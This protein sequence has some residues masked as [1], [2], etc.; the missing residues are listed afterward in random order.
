MAEQ[1]IKTRGK[2]VYDP[3]RRGFKKGYKVRTLIAELPRDELDLYYQWFLKKRYGEWLWLQRPMFGLHVTVVRGDENGFKSNLWGAYAGLKVDLE[4][5][6]IIRH[7]WGFWSLPVRGNDLLT[8]RQGLGLKAQH[9]FH[10][11]VG[12]Q[13]D[14]QK[15]ARWF[16]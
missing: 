10:V 8:L 11:T 6:P 14:W 7:H 13:Q 3:V 1:W 12:R 4:Y 9:D 5:G 15:Q 16:E 2:L